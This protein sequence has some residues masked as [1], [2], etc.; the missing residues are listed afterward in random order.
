MSTVEQTS[1]EQMLNI[2]T[3]VEVKKNWHIINT[4]DITWTNI[5]YGYHLWKDNIT[6]YDWSNKF[7]W[8]KFIHYEMV[9]FDE[10]NIPEHF[11][12]LTTN[13]KHTFDKGLKTSNFGKTKWYYRFSLSVII[14]TQVDL[15]L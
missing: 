3:V 1:P 6:G 12:L 14:P 5:K 8:N 15:V 10:K 9:W 13:V 7:T 11:Y 2:N 4:E